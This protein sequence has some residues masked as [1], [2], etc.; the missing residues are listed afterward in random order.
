MKSHLTLTYEMNL[1]SEWSVEVNRLEM[2]EKFFID[3]IRLNLIRID[4]RL[5]MNPK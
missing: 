2:M 3:Y 4:E 1:K 5:N